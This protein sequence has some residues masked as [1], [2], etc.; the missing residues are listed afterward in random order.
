M[1]KPPQ[2]ERRIIPKAQLFHMFGRSLYKYLVKN[3]KLLALEK[4]DC[5]RE[6]SDLWQ[7]CIVD[8]KSST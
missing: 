2:Y 4:T 1:R 7:K 6:K 5:L 8:K 3:L